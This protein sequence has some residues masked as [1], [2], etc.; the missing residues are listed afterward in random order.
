M[1]LSNDRVTEIYKAFLAD[2]RGG[3]LILIRDLKD[4][5]SYETSIEECR[6][7]GRP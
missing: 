3:F 2:S 6:V 7:Y 1:L 5:D 4:T